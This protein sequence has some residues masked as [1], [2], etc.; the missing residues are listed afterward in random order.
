MG[1]EITSSPYFGWIYGTTNNITFCKATLYD[2]DFWGK[3]VVLRIAGVNWHVNNL[4]WIP[5]KCNFEKNAKNI[6][7][8]AFCCCISIFFIGFEKLFSASKN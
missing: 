3:I 6:F 5:N 4:D 2:Y 1:N 7:T 8:S